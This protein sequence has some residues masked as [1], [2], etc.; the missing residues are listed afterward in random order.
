MLFVHCLQLAMQAQGMQMRIA[1]HESRRGMATTAQPLDG[2]LLLVTSFEQYHQHIEHQDNN[3]WTP[4]DKRNPLLG[5][6]LRDN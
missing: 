3:I 4:P 2:V 5:A 1:V 6:G